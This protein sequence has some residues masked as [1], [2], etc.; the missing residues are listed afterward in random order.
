[1]RAGYPLR[2]HAIGNTCD[3]MPLDDRVVRWLLD[4]ERVG[5]SADLWVDAPA[6]G[7]K[8]ELVVEIE[9]RHGKSRKSVELEV[10][11]VPQPRE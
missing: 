8:H 10:V 5:D 4:G 7:G 9:D 2:L 3:G 6:K 1:M 11:E